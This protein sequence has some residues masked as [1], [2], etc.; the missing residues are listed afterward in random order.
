MIDPYY[1]KAGGG[2]KPYPLETRLHIHLLQNWFSLSDPAMG[3]ALYEITP[4]RQFADLTLCAPI[5]EDTTIMS[6]RHLLEKHKLA[7]AILAVFN[8]YLQEK[9]LSLRPDTLVDATIIH[10]HGSTKNEDGKHDPE[11]HQTKKSDQY[12]FAIKVHI[13][14]DVE[15]RLVHHVHGTAENVADVTQVAEL[16][17]DRENAVYADA[18]YTGVEKRDEHENREVLLAT[19][20]LFQSEQAQR[21]IQSQAQN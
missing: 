14:A 20:H 17:H 2:R 18:G 4:M 7:P 15:S 3:E 16:L 12:F 21:A 13:G 11:M 10:A 8:G 1:P 9:G 6:L 5:F 19:H